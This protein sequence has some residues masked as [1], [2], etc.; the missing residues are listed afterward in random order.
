[1]HHTNNSPSPLLFHPVMDLPGDPTEHRA[2]SNVIDHRSESGL[3]VSGNIMKDSH[4]RNSYSPPPDSLS[5][6][7]RQRTVS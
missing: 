3:F 5:A 2:D 6:A 1:M 4:L 7:P